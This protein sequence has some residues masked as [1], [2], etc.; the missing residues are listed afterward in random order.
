MKIK[1]H[2]AIIEVSEE[3]LKALYNFL[4][5]TDILKLWHEGGCTYEQIDIWANMRSTIKDYLDTVQK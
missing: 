5:G 1:Q 4:E 3:E 2:G